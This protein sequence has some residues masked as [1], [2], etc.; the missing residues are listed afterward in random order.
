MPRTELV[1][2]GKKP[3]NGGGGVASG[4]DDPGDDLKWKPGDDIY[5]QMPNGRPPS[6]RTV[7][8]RFWKN[9]AKDPSRSDYTEEDFARMEE[10]LPPQRYNAEKGGIE[11]MERSHEPAP[12]RDGGTRMVPR[13]PQE[14]AEVDPHRRPGY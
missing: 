4:A 3:P 6:D 13:W 10:G 1:G 12:R 8:R 9:E 11:S 2:G 14:H 7:G 5:A